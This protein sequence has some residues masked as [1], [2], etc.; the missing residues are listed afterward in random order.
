MNKSESKYF[1]T[2]VRMDKALLELL[3]T[4]EF[5]YITVKEIC[6][7]ANVNRST[8]YLHYDNTMDLLMESVQYM[9]EHFLSYFPKQREA[10][11]HKLK[12]SDKSDLIFLKE[13][14]LYPYLKYVYDNKRLF[15]IAMD[16]ASTLQLD[17]TYQSMFKHIFYPIMERFNISDD[18]KKYVLA[19][20]INGIIAIIREWLKE[21]CKT[22]ME[23]ISDIIIKY[24]LP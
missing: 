10:I 21:D 23:K 8:F 14:Y 15:S 13:E 11:T 22:S 6:Q 2:A 17:K 7:K 16:N 18:E 3:E 9:N 24:V 4:K 19:F 20:H 5:A 12:S 1:N